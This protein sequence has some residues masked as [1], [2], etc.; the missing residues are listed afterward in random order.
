[1]LY[2]EPPASV[3]EF[4]FL[5]EKVGG[6]DS[7]KGIRFDERKIHF[8]G[9]PYTEEPEW[10]RAYMDLATAICNEALIT[11]KVKLAKAAP[12]NERYFF[13]VWL[14]RIG[15]SGEKYKS[16]RKVLLSKLE[17]NAAFRTRAQELEHRA[18]YERKRLGE[19]KEN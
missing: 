10:I 19:D 9:F 14:V 8:E 12:D 7:T 16:S 2:K 3:S 11:K 15:F 6:E 17:G 13:R 5:W 4:L 1:M 18:K